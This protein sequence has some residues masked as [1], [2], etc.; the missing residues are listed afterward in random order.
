MAQLVRIP[1]C[2]RGPNGWAGSRPG[3]ARRSA[4]GRR[5][6][7]RDRHDVHPVFRDR[8]GRRGWPELCP[9][10]GL[11]TIRAGPATR[12]PSTSAPTPQ[13][14][15]W[16]S[17]RGTIPRGVEVALRFAG[18]SGLSRLISGT[19]AWDVRGDRVVPTP[20]LSERRMLEILLTPHG[21][22]KAAM[23]SSPTAVT[24]NEYGGRVTVVSFLALGRY[25]VNGTV[26][27]GNIAQR[28]QT[29]L[30]NPVVG[31]MY[32][33]TVY[34]NY[35][36]VGGG[37]QFPMRWHQHQDYDDGAHE[38]NVSGGDHAF[39]LETI[40]DVRINV[41]NAEVTIPAE[42]QG[43]PVPPVRVETE[44]LADGIWLLGGG[45]HNSVAVEFEEPR[46]R[47]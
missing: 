43:A 8:V 22:L 3:R 30:P 34:T 5:H 12:G 19:R 29:W 24:R 23:A 38:P 47:H 45:S 26:T 2:G 7:G 32:Y 27:E 31:D 35:Q 33:E 40:S 16:S 14:K 21:F 37:V 42:V 13:R 15:R 28:V 11:A 1:R 4:G 39:G 46:R 20:E 41:G 10:S 44:Q 36:D 25:R 18:S 17:D 9:G 6:Y